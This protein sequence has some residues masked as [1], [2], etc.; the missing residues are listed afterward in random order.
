MRFVHQ[1]PCGDVCLVCIATWLEK[2]KYTTSQEQGFSGG[3]GGAAHDG[4]TIQLSIPF[5]S[6][7]CENDNTNNA[8]WIFRDQIKFTYL[9]NPICG[10]RRWAVGG[11]GDGDGDGENPARRLATDPQV[12][13]V[14]SPPTGPPCPWPGHPR[15]GRAS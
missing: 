10:R 4:R 12:W 8:L 3:R 7:S 13:W 11:V 6:I 9:W 15:P 1:C 14:S 2:G 5:T